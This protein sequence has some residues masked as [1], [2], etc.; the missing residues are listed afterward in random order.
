MRLHVTPEVLFVE[1]RALTSWTLD[2]AGQ[3]D[4]VLGLDERLEIYL[5]RLILRLRQYGGFIFVCV[6][7]HHYLRTQHV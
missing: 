6:F 4:F 2:G 1:K 7:V 3:A 5:R